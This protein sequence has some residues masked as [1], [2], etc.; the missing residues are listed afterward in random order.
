M[1]RR[2]WKKSAG[3]TYH[4][5]TILVDGEPV[6]G[7]DFAYGYDSHYIET[8]AEKLESL[9]LIKRR[10]RFAGSGMVED[11]RQY[12]ERHKIALH[13]QATDVQ[14]KKDL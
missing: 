12:C 14:R 5:S 10:K 2:W 13:C 8:A 6:E 7:V 3:S 9:G 11:L 4:A 1:G